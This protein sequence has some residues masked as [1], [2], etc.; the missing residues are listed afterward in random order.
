MALPELAYRLMGW[1]STTRFDRILH[2]AL[3]RRFGERAH[4]GFRVYRRRSPIHIP[5]L[6]LEPR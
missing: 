5:V 2:P 1:F 3:Y 4:P 6:R